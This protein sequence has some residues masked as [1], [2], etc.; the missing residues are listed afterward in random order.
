MNRM[1]TSAERIKQLR[2]QQLMD[3]FMDL[4]SD[5]IVVVDLEGKVIEV[6]KGFEELHGWT[7]EEVIGKV[8][9]M[10]PEE[11]KE[12]VFRLY[13][14]IIAGEQ[15]SN[16]ESLKMR[17]DGS[18]FIANV[19]IS[20]LKD[21]NGKVVAFVGIERDIT[22]RKKAEE[23]L[24]ESE[25]RYRVLVE[26]SP[27]PIVVYSNGRISYANAA[28]ARL[29]GAA[30][31]EALIG[32]RVFRF[33][34]PAYLTLTKQVQTQLQEGK[35]SEL[36]E[37]KLIRLDG[38]AIDV[39]VRAVPVKFQG[40]VSVQLLFRDVTD[41]KRAE[42]KLI[43]SENQF[44]RL[45]KLSPEPIVLHC[46]GII[47]FVN[48]IGS[49]LFKGDTDQE[50]INRHILDFFLPEEHAAIISRL[51]QSLQADDFLE[52]KGYK[53]KRLDGV[54][55]DVEISSIYV[56]RQMGSPVI[57]SV[58]R[59]MTERMKT[60]EYV[61]TSEKLAIVG[62]L[63]AGI[64]HEIRN[65]LTSLKGFAQ[66][67]KARNTDYV[68]IM[69]DELDRINYI[70]NEFMTIAKPHSV[71]Y[72]E[73]ELQSLVLSV[74][75]FMEPQA[76]L[77]NV[78]LKL[79][80]EM[81]M[82]PVRC[83]PNQI[84]Q[85][86]MNIIKNAIESMPSGGIVQISLRQLDEETALICI[87]DHG[88]GIPEDYLAKL[89]EPFFSMKEKGTGLGLMVCQQI[90]KAHNGKLSIRSKINQGTTVEIELPCHSDC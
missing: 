44:R 50:I 3:S 23:E 52:F 16:Q 2:A 73:H 81:Q 41:R 4:T 32:K 14:R 66:M 77:F 79:A 86:I 75:H 25:E 21:E 12:D 82:R 78:N 19:T 31:S 61:R 69:L 33:I 89:G 43:E 38:E 27:E 76:L 54:I 36:I 55:L 30:S 10:T 29:V 90:V 22:P 35:A 70:V 17:K 49:R 18:S 62:Q 80:V 57:Q 46:N 48:D 39:E 63:A 56:H 13:E 64:A 42:S 88:I 37:I 1:L 71:I 53:M 24:K 15:F 59:D 8:L 5:G 9:P 84:K 51:N 67:L 85:V 47:Q 68:D 72:T 83:E 26:C 60:E 45:L 6:N 58:V 28:A 34:H 11:C 74:V 87:E 65:P 40:S 7:R 20:T